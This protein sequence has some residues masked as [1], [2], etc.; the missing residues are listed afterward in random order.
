MGVTTAAQ[1]GKSSPQR[2][3]AISRKWI[4]AG[5]GASFVVVLS[6]VGLVL[7]LTR[8]QA[9]EMER[10]VLCADAKVAVSD[11]VASLGS[12]RAKQNAAANRRMWTAAADADRKV[13]ECWNTA[14]KQPIGGKGT[15][16]ALRAAMTALT[17]HTQKYTPPAI[18]SRVP[19]P[20]NPDNGNWY[21]PEETGD[22]YDE[23]NS[24]SKPCYAY[25][26]IRAIGWSYDTFGSDSTRV[27][28][29]GWEF[30]DTWCEAMRGEREPPRY[31]IKVTERDPIYR[32]S[33][34]GVTVVQT[35]VEKLRSFETVDYLMTPKP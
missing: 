18:K 11:A 3:R 16:E 17:E 24:N 27:P 20:R 2:A 9:P 22:H 35:Q 8:S 26:G 21:V 14:G 28:P 25:A 31:V 15:Q 1:S 12:V 7:A 13:I 30:Y 6:G 10:T 34:S 32:L 23:I 4:A 29:P 19:L 33:A 5:V